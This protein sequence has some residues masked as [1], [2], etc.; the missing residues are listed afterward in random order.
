MA[1]RFMYKDIGCYL[2]VAPTLEEN[3]YSLVIHKRNYCIGE[4]IHLNVFEFTSS[5]NIVCFIH[6]RARPL[7]DTLLET[8]DKER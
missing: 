3:L 7:I 1:Y 4:I 8:V 2:T 6:K 5:S